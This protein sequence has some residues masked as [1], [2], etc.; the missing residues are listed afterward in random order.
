M[1]WWNPIPQIKSHRKSDEDPSGWGSFC[2]LRAS[3]GND[4]IM[5][6]ASVVALPMKIKELET[7]S[8]PALKFT[9]FWD[10]VGNDKGC[11]GHASLRRCLF[12]HNKALIESGWCK[13]RQDEKF[14]WNPRSNPKPEYVF[15]IFGQPPTTTRRD[16]GPDCHFLLLSTLFL[17]WMTMRPPKN[18]R[19]LNKSLNPRMK[20]L[21]Q[22]GFVILKP[23]VAWNM[24]NYVS[25]SRHHL[26]M[27]IDSGESHWEVKM[28]KTKGF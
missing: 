3:T 18:L 12:H 24:A 25:L 8:W 28:V 6:P 7:T 11:W 21:L 22:Q 5:A 15:M 1:I 19:K 13:W 23:V 4:K 2:L 20:S 10:V 26:W 14:F 17:Y 27:A 16:K 9:P